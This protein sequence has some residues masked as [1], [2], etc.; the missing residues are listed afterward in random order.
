MTRFEFCQWETSRHKTA[1][2]GTRKLLWKKTFSEKI[3][4]KTFKCAKKC[5]KKKSIKLNWFSFKI[6]LIKNQLSILRTFGN[7]VQGTN[8]NPKRKSLEIYREESQPSDIF[9]FFLSP[10]KFLSFFWGCAKK[11]HFTMGILNIMNHSGTIRRMNR[12][13]RTYLW[14][15]YNW[16]L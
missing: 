5:Q 8:M 11:K 13:L 14:I 9:T 2:S 12:K 6:K 15:I 3:K 1:R 16:Y 7:D 10:F 4:D